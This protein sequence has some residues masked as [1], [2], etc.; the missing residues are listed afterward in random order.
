[1]QKHKLDPH[2]VLVPCSYLPAKYEYSFGLWVLPDSSAPSSEEVVQEPVLKY[3]THDCKWAVATATEFPEE[4]TVCFYDVVYF[5]KANMDLAVNR[6]MDMAGK[7]SMEDWFYLSTAEFLE[8]KLTPP[9]EGGLK[10]NVWVN[11]ETGWWH[12]ETDEDGFYSCESRGC[13]FA[14][15]DVVR[16]RQWLRSRY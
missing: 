5:D 1:M 4:N 12:Y 6:L 10:R 16:V 11:P 2:P 7:P 3:E 13:K 15:K 9:S 8:A 14:D